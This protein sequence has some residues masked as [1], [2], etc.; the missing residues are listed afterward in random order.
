[1]RFAL[2]LA[3]AALATTAAHAHFVFVYVDG[4]DAKVVFGHHAAPDPD[5]FPTRAEKTTL[6]ARDAAGKET[7]LTLEK[8]AGNFF[9]AKLPAAP[10]VV[11]G[12]TE[13][14]VT[15]KG[16]APPVLSWYHP[17]VIVGD[18]FAANVAA[19]KV[20]DIVPVRDGDKVRFRVLA[21]GKALADADVT[22]GIDG[23]EETKAETVKTGADGL[24][25]AFAGGG[26]YLVAARRVEAKAGEFGGK[27]YTAVRHTA[28]LVCDVPGR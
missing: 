28:T 18:P 15:Q 6:T 12:T 23:K 21:A 4:G 7:P 3:L 25:P 22:V 24:T 13:S 17:K 11:Y 2:T 20:M 14:G 5:S 27:S 1:M 9:R 16:D 19:G 26:R 8:G 10:V